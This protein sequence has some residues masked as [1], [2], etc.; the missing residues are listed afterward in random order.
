MKQQAAW[1]CDGNTLDEAAKFCRE[2]LELALAH[3]G[4]IHYLIPNPAI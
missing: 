2:A 3:R 1:L 4:E